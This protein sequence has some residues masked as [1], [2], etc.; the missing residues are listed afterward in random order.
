MNTFLEMI[1]LSYL[2]I[3]LYQILTGHSWPTGQVW[4]VANILL[5]LVTPWQGYVSMAPEKLRHSNPDAIFCAVI[6]MVT[7][8][9]SILS[10]YY[11]VHRWNHDKLPRPSWNRN[12]LNWWH[13]PL[14]SLFISAYFA[15]G[16]A[17]GC[18]L[19]RPSFGSVGFWMLGM[20]ICVALGLSVGQILVY[21]IFRERI[22]G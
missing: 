12:P 16:M 22:T 10:V 11:S 14:Q 13:D 17:F 19:R 7:P 2:A 20:Y 6:L 21:R 1:G 9:F 18:A 5:F 4:Y 15:Y 8:L 3:A